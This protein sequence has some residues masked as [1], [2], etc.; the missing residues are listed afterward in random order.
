MQINALSDRTKI[1][2]LFFLA[3]VFAISGFVALFLP[4]KNHTALLGVAIMCFVC[5]YACFSKGYD[6]RAAVRRGEL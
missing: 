1:T 5:F 6:L 3:S 2:V 4:N